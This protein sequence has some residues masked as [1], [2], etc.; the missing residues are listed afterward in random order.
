MKLLPSNFTFID[1]FAG[2]GGFHLA[3]DQY[4]KGKARCVLASEID[5]Q[6]SKIYEANFHLKPE[7]DIR[8]VEAPKMPFDV[9]CG[10]FPCQTFSKA[11]KQ[12]GFA[13]SRGTLF[14]E[15]VRI[16][17]SYDF[18]DRPKILVLENVRNLASHDKGHTW[19]VIRDS[20]RQCG[21]TINDMP[22]IL[23]PN[24][25]GVPQLRERSIILGV[26]NDIFSG[27]IAIKFP[28][29]QKNT[30]S[31]NSIL[32]K[33]PCNYIPLTESQIKL[34]DIWDD[35]VHS[36]DRKI[37]GFPVW[38]D[39]FDNYMQVDASFPDWKLSFVNANKRLYKENQTELKKW[40]KRSKI[41]SFNATS[42]KFEWQMGGKYESVYDGII[43][44]RTSGIRVKQPTE[45]P[46]LVAMVHLPYIG[47]ERRAISVREAARLQSFTENFRFDEPVHD[48]YKQLGNA[49]NVKV[50]ESSFAALINFLEKECKA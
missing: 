24:D 29:A 17:K 47:Q 10:G 15:I 11:G 18:K 14:H 12:A 28:K 44:F 22:F 9:L 5:S 37:I 2:I 49:V 35:F 23:S 8:A 40:I 7:G 4:S 26:R 50:I 48:A 36:V 3:M 1:L 38:S 34:L 43:Q 42:R 6:A 31:I 13:D 27:N 19:K 45:S 46:A 30:L 16:I 20:L 32:E 41:R 21:Y 39:Y 25:F 33:E